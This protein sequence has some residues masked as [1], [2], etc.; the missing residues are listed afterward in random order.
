MKKKIR[1]HETKETKNKKEDVVPKG[2]VPAYLLDRYVY[3]LSM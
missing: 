3:S 2:A 1:I